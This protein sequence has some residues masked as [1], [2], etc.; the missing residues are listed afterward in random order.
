MPKILTLRL[1]L[2]KVRARIQSPAARAI[3]RHL[4]AETLDAFSELTGKLDEQQRQD[5]Q[6]NIGLKMEQLKAELE[7][8]LESDDH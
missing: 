2:C 5:T 1:S 4:R 6:R 7:L 3:L 8:L